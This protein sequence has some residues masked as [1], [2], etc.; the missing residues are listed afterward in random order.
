MWRI[1]YGH[2]FPHRCKIFQMLQAKPDGFS[3]GFAVGFSSKK[4]TKSGN[5][6]HGIAERGRLRWR[7]W[8]FRRMCTERLPFSFLEKYGAGDIG[9]FTTQFGQVEDAPSDDHINSQTGFDAARATQLSF[10]NLAA[11]LESAMV[12]LNSPSA[13]IPI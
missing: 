7:N 8:I 6:S 13:G 11:T 12:N 1:A 10:F 2:E 5:H 3:A 4:A 9:S